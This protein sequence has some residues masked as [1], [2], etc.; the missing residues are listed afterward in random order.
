M[1]YVIPFYLEQASVSL[2]TGKFHRLCQPPSVKLKLNVSQSCR[3]E[4][5]ERVNVVAAARAGASFYPVASA[6]QLRREGTREET[7][8]T[9]KGSK[10]RTGGGGKKQRLRYTRVS[11]R[12]PR[13]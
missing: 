6:M 11:R 8:A 9:L 1:R 4:S 7:R 13:T 2:S 10:E 12:E 3:G 5:L